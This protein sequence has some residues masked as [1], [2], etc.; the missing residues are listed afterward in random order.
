MGGKT[1]SSVFGLALLGTLLVSA[2]F[3]AD[4][5]TASLVAGGGRSAAGGTIVNE[6]C[7][8]GLAGVAVG[9]RAVARH[10]FAGQLVDVR[11]LSV[12]GDPR[13]VGEAATAQLCGAAILD[14]DS[15]TLLNGDEIA[16]DIPAWPLAGIDANGAA[17]AAIIY[18]DTPAT[19]GGTY[20]GVH[21]TGSL[22]VLDT[23]PDN[24]GSY[25]FDGLPDA[26]QVGNFG[27]DHAA[28]GPKD[29]PDGDGQDN[30]F[31]HVAGVEPTNAASRFVLRIAT[32]PGQ[33]GERR[34]IFRPRWPD[35]AYTPEFRTNLAA[36]TGW[37]TLETTTVSDDGTERTVTDLD[38]NAPAKFY[39][40]GIAYP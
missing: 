25:A 18:A 8:G 22:L 34:L 38:A 31:E 23:S 36:G 3:A 27:F 40:V 32:V 12:S 6:G 30:R 33:P 2:S 1:S 10:G 19:A 21:G 11:S 5:T 37:Q 14:D 28:A 17:T 9:E 29:D 24:F 16:W 26:W 39:Q 35:R 4:Q 7:I 13:Q 15:T 20:A